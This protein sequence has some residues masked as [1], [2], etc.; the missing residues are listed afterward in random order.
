MTKLKLFLT[1][2]SA[3]IDLYFSREAVQELR[4]LGMVVCNP[5]DRRLTSAELLEYA[6]DAEVI[7]SEWNTGMD[8]SFIENAK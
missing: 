8:R 4:D 1:H 6:G 7:I 3:E 5:L 2:T